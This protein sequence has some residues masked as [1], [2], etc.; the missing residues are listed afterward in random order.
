MGTLLQIPETIKGV[1]TSEIVE[2]L[3]LLAE[4]SVAG[5]VEAA[6]LLSKTCHKVK[7]G[8]LMDPN[9]FLFACVTNAFKQQ[10]PRR[11]W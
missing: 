6:F 3:R 1:L 2:H 11:N 5:R 7:T 8:Q 10:V 4:G 9:G